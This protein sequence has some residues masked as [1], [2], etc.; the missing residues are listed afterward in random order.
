MNTEL[1]RVTDSTVYQYKRSRKVTFVE[2]ARKE[3]EKGAFICYW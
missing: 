1:R 3:L 2:A